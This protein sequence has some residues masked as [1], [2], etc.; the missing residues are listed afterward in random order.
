MADTEYQKRE[1]AVRAILN[2][3]KTQSEVA[4]EFGMTRQAVSLWIKKYKESGEFAKSIGRGRAARGIT[5]A[6]RDEY[7]QLVQR[8]K[9]SDHGYEVKDDVWCIEA[10][11]AMLRKKFKRQFSLKFCFSMLEEAGVK[12][13]SYGEEQLR[14]FDLAESRRQSPTPLDESEVEQ[15][16][17]SEEELK[18]YEGKVAEARREMAVKGKKRAPKRGAAFTKPKK[19]KKNKSGKRK[20]K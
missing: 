16:V 17:M 13:L 7:V 19:K 20:K 1:E 9:P 15:H 4:R 11:G 8:T 18:Y 5:A 14:E 10:L 2:K 3:E 12:H 6:Q